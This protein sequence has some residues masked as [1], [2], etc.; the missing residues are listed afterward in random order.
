MIYQIF[1]Q[2]FLDRLEIIDLTGYT[3][4]EKLLIS[5]NYIIPSALKKHGLKKIQLL[6]L[7]QMP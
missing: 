6:N 7:K 3:D 2:H 5:E 1:H 4:N